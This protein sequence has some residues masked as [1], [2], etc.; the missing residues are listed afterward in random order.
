MSMYTCC[1]ID[2]LRSG[3]QAVVD[4]TI[5]V[6]SAN[7][8]VRLEILQYL[9][10]G[11]TKAFVGPHRAQTIGSSNAVR[12]ATEEDTQ[13]LKCLVLGLRGKLPYEQTTQSTEYGEDIGTILHRAEHILGG[14][15]DNEVEH[16]VDG[17]DDRDTAGALTVG[18]DF[19]T[20]Y[21]RDGSYSIKC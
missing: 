18:E 19:L 12:I 1:Y 10:T 21:L 9:D 17:G 3:T 8:L 15:A 4:L 2:H 5:D 14:K 20:Q 16:P 13:L 11:K 7:L 6:V